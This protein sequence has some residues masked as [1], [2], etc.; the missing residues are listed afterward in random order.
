MVGQN[1]KRAVF[2]TLVGLAFACTSAQADTNTPA[3]E[4][5]KRWN[6]DASLGFQTDDNVTTDEVDSVSNLADTASI[7][8]LSGTYKA[9]DGPEGEIELGYDFFQSFYDDLAVC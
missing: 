7:I 3:D 6:I 5:E 9:Y 4:G 2:V 8:E 1:F